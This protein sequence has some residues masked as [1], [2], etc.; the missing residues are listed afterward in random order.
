[1]NVPV[2][3]LTNHFGPFENLSQ[4]LLY[5][6][7]G[8]ASRVPFHWLPKLVNMYDHI[9]KMFTITP[10]HRGKNQFL[11][12]MSSRFSDKDPPVNKAEISTRGLK[13]T[14]RPEQ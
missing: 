8:R 2:K 12:L 3:T 6:G 1:M 11:F 4:F 13:E 9:L 7:P 5:P 14:L 10:G